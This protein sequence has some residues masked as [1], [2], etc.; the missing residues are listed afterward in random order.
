[1]NN[2]KYVVKRIYSTAIHPSQTFQQ[3]PTCSECVFFN[4]HKQTCKKFNCKSII[5]R[6]SPFK[7]GL[8]ASHFIPK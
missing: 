2:I 8:N 4:F 6:I 5:A 1:M 3:I 7:C